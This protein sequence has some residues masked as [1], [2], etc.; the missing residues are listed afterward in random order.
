M[1]IRTL[2]FP[3]SEE[4][5]NNREMNHMAKIVVSLNRNAVAS[6]SPRLARPRLPWVRREN[7]SYPNE[8]ASLC[9]GDGMRRLF[10]GKLY[11]GNGGPNQPDFRIRARTTEHHILGCGGK[12]QDFLLAG[13][14][15]PDHREIE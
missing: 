2:R 15:H 11:L 1:S 14:D 4:W 10:A 5:S 7:T 3:R 9:E 6:F 13:H 8:V 12:L